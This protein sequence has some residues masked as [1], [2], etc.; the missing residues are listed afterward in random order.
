MS[1]TLAIPDLPIEG[2][3][4]ESNLHLGG[5]RHIVRFPNGY[6]ASVVRNRMSYGDDRGLYEVGVITYDR[7]KPS[8]W[9]LTY[10]TPITDNMLGWQSVEDVAEVL[11]RISR[12][13]SR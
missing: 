4:V 13:A 3:D 10:D 9:D 12:L 8:D 11:L 6:G 5:E 1:D 2:I 7:A